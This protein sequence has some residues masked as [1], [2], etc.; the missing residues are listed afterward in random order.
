M[1]SAYTY[2]TS[3]PT[4]GSRSYLLLLRI[5]S[6]L[7]EFILL[8]VSETGQQERSMDVEWREILPARPSSV[9]LVEKAFCPSVRAFHRKRLRHSLTRLPVTVWGAAWPRYV[10]T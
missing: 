7:V 5:S 4:R 8:T 10:R 1:K 3:Q 2:G 6:S 9:F